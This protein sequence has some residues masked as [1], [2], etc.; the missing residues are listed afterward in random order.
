MTR[1]QT[2]GVCVS[3]TEADLIRELARREGFDSVSPFLRRIVLPAVVARVEEL[4]EEPA[5]EPED[6]TP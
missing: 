3:A 4:T 6:A 2:L 1:D 5:P